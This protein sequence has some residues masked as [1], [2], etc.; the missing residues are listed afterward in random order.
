MD[1]SGSRVA[2]RDARSDEAETL[3]RIEAQCFETDRMSRR[4]L[5]RHLRSDS[6]DVLIA[7]LAGPE[8][9]RRVAGYAMVFYRANA[10]VARLYS[11]ATLPEARGK[12]VADA[13]MDAAEK[14]VRRRGYTALR[15]EVRSDN[16]AATRLYAKRGYVE[17]GAHE[18]YY[19]DGMSARRFEKALPARS[20]KRAA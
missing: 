18:N 2:I 15:L 14:A 13:L 16:P 11:I 19:A 7:E 20:S 5:N 4:S 9:D 17:F 8:Q 3:E 10:S 1:P 6:A 12:G